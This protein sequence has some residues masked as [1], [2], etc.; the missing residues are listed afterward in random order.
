MRTKPIVY[1]AHPYSRGHINQNVAV[2]CVQWSNL[3]T[4]NKVVPFN[5]LWSHLQDLVRPMPY[6]QWLDYDLALIES[7]M[8]DAVLRCLP[9]SESAGSDEEIELAHR[10]EIPV[11]FNTRDLYEWAEEWSM[12]ALVEKAGLA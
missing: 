5:P 10:L 8:F 9:D 3:F 2:S 6:R 12:R 1:M 11:F 4:E 7:G